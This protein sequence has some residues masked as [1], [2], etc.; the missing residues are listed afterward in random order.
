MFL[1]LV[2]QAYKDDVD[3]VC[4]GKRPGFGG[5]EHPNFFCNAESQ[6]TPEE[7]NTY[8]KSQHIFR[9]QSM[10]FC[11]SFAFRAARPWIG[12]AR[13]VLCDLISQHAVGWMQIAGLG[14]E[15]D[16]VRLSGI[17]TGWIEAVQKGDTNVEL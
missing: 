14:D 13:R 4:R 8:K 6:A 12:S 9:H 7:E 3:L 11:Q 2:T 15:R 16:A 17:F 1:R 5:S 10:S